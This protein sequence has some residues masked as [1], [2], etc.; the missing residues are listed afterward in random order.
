M[1]TLAFLCLLL[2]SAFTLP[3]TTY[4]PMATLSPSTIE[5]LEQLATDYQQFAQLAKENKGSYQFSEEQKQRIK[6]AKAILGPYLKAKKQGLITPETTPPQEEEIDPTS[7]INACLGW[8]DEMLTFFDATIASHAD[9]KVELATFQQYLKRKQSTI[10][11]TQSLYAE[12]VTVVDQLAAQEDTT[13]GKILFEALRDHE[14]EAWTTTGDGEKLKAHYK[15]HRKTYKKLNIDMGDFKEDALPLMQSL[16]DA[17]SMSTSE[18]DP[19]LPEN[20]EEAKEDAKAD[21]ERMQTKWDNWLNQITIPTLLEIDTAHKGKLIDVGQLEQQR[22]EYLGGPVYAK[23]F[24]EAT[25]AGILAE[26][27]A[28]GGTPSYDQVVT[29]AIEMVKQQ[30]SSHVD[31]EAFLKMAVES[32]EDILPY[33]L[34]RWIVSSIQV[35]DPFF[36]QF[37]EAT[38]EWVT[39]VKGVAAAAEGANNNRDFYV[40]VPK[41]RNNLSNLLTDTL[42]GLSNTLLAGFTDQKPLHTDAFHTIWKQGLLRLLEP[43]VLTTIWQTNFIQVQSGSVEERL[44]QYT[45]QLP[46]LDTLTQALL[47]ARYNK[48]QTSKLP[49]VTIDSTFEVEYVFHWK[50]RAALSEQAIKALLE[51]SESVTGISLEDIRTIVDGAKNLL[52]IDQEDQTNQPIDTVRLSVPDDRFVLHLPFV[53]ASIKGGDGEWIAYPKIGSLS[54]AQ[55]KW[56]KESPY[57]L[58]TTQVRLVKE[59]VDNN[60][61]MQVVEVTLEVHD[62]TLSRNLAFIA[63]LTTGEAGALYSM[64]VELTLVSEY[65]GEQQQVL[66]HIVGDTTPDATMCPL[67]E[68]TDGPV[69]QNFIGT[70]VNEANNEGEYRPLEGE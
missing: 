1:R 67:L 45:T 64:T 25:S 54:S 4:L 56:Q 3:D 31:N 49:L 41:W 15:K 12:W 62:V 66:Y 60:T 29:I 23:D 11:M 24:W 5:K 39:Q 22:G 26:V 33:G 70:V 37:A 53:N 38:Q 34:K 42:Y 20:R 32:Q 68:H 47:D 17:L 14:G 50:K 48:P 35:A 52:P 13:T 55:L 44:Q 36:E 57:T 8:R 9:V 2:S 6:T 59:V 27:K 63:G 61:V 30:Y 69:L 21:L 19:N 16:K 40:D 58:E 7:F 46:S 43:H 18:E 65:K 51:E 10:P 28:T